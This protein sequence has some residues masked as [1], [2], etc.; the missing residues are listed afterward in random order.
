MTL[1]ELADR[2]ACS[3][4]AIS[5]FESGDRRPSERLVAA[6]ALALGFPSG[7]FFAGKIE[8]L[9]A[10]SRSETSSVATFRSLR[11]LTARSRARALASGV[12][13]AEF[14]RAI[15][16]RVRTPEVRLPDLS[17]HGPET[18]AATLRAAWTLGT[19]PISNA[20]HVIE[21]HG[22]RAFWMRDECDEVDAFSFWREG[23][24]FMMLSSKKTPERGRR[25]VGH[26]L[27]HLVLH[28]NCQVFDRTVEDEAEQFASAF[29]LPKAQ[30]SAEC[31][32]N[33]TPARIGELKARWAVSRASVVRRAFELDLM[34][35]WRYRSEFV[36]M[37]ETGRV[38][39]AD[40]IAR[41]ESLLFTR[42]MPMFIESGIYL[43][44][45]AE[46]LFVRVSELLNLIPLQAP[47]RW[48]SAVPQGRVVAWA[49]T[50]RK[51][52]VES[53]APDD[54]SGSDLGSWRERS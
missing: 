26:E 48:V 8:P 54:F 28:K 19:G 34:T 25:D 33:P 15:S 47:E 20:L 10:E 43:S 45:L 46:E 39:E 40:P 38:I 36:A 29:L 13:A 41:E 24:P 6:L 35:E 1:R 14:S 12:I 49:P 53:T 23:Q 7:F 9:S 52:I 37:A 3:P 11:S 51:A 31:G 17:E 44:D 50:P 4:A 18:A 32:A 30:F 5:Q 27:G 21:A 2:V 42:L 22:G 16:H